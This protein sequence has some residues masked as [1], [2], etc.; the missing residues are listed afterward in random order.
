M[1]ISIR[2]QDDYVAT[3]GFSIGA[4]QEEGDWTPAGFVLADQFQINLE[5]QDGVD[6]EG[7]DLWNNWNENGVNWLDPEYYVLSIDV[8]GGLTASQYTGDSDNPLEDYSENLQWTITGWD[9]TIL[10]GYIEDGRLVV[11]PANTYRPFDPALNVNVQENFSGYTQTELTALTFTGDVSEIGDSTVFGVELLS[12]NYPWEVCDFSCLGC[13]DMFAC[14]Y[15]ADATLSDD[16]CEYDSC[17]GCT[18]PTACNYLIDATIPDSSCD[19]TSCVGCMEEGACNYNMDSTIES[20]DCEYESCSGCTDENACDY[21]PTATIAA[22]CDYSC[23]GCMDVNG[24]DYDEDAT[25]EGDCDYSCNGCMD[26][27]ACDYDATATAQVEECDF[28]SC[29]GCLDDVNACNYCSDCEFPTDCIY[30]EDDATCAGCTDDAY[31]EFS[32]DAII[33]NGS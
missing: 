2:D 11:S 21:V 31:M 6:S 18:Q 4:F 25:I 30:P 16:S 28:D 5:Y 27:T 23:V 15:D 9:H 7:V 13:V 24:C 22:D 32:S 29:F 26:S 33:D 3:T 12:D 10:G 14:N 17:A 20:G 19:F 1:I 8:D